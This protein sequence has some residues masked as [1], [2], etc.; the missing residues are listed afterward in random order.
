MTNFNFTAH[1]TL[2]DQKVYLDS[3]DPKSLVNLSRSSKGT[4]STHVKCLEQSFLTK[5]IDENEPRPVL[6]KG[7]TGNLEMMDGSHRTQAAL[8]LKWKTLQYDII[9]PSNP[10]TFNYEEFLMVK[11]L[12]ANDHNPQKSVST[13][14]VRRRVAQYVDE[15]RDN[16]TKEKDVLDIISLMN[17][18]SL[19]VNQKECIAHRVFLDEVNSSQIDQYEKSEAR[20]RFDTILN[21]YTLES[22]SGK[23]GARV[24][25]DAV[26]NAIEHY[27]ATGEQLEIVLLTRNCESMHQVIDTRRSTVEIWKKNYRTI[28]NVILQSDGVDDNNVI[29]YPFRVVGAI[30]QIVGQEEPN[31]LVTVI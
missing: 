26:I 15:H 25:W 17:I 31:K 6:I 18:K 13:T 19:T 12:E 4:D 11:G 27:D 7:P 30:P 2:E 24:E 21:G 10:S 16:F 14:D 28:R 29:R 3:I 5:G 9:I 23:D 1:R 22:I 8:N 20:K